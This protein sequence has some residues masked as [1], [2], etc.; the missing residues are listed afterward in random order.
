MKTII[1]KEPYWSA[2][3]RYQWEHLVWGVGLNK[4]DLY[5]ANNT[6]QDIHIVIEKTGNE[7]TANPKKLIR[8]AENN[9]CKFKVKGVELYVIPHTM[10]DEYDMWKFE[11]PRATPGEALKEIGK[12][13][14][15]SPGNTEVFFQIVGRDAVIELPYKVKVTPKLKKKVTK[16]L[17]QFTEE[18]VYE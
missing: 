18:V 13:L 1:I 3:K 6:G 2:Y 11:I 16:I 14:K 10:L 17:D 9:D 12:M 15:E 5:H 4:L 8:F 7:Y